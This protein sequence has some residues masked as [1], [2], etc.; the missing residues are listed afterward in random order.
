MQQSPKGHV[1]ISVSVLMGRVRL[2]PILKRLREAY[3]YIE[4]ELSFEDRNVD[5]LTEKVD[6][7]M[8]IGQLPD[9]SLIAR[10]ISEKCWGGFASPEYLTARGYPLKPDDLLGRIT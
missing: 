8:R 3:P 5:L 4:L 6:I 9:S 2:V 7:A 1:R 10:K